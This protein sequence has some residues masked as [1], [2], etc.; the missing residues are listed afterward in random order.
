MADPP[1]GCAPSGSSDPA[2]YYRYFDSED[3]I[4]KPR[5]PAG[6]WKLIE[7]WIFYNYDS[8]HAGALTQW[9]QADWEQVSVLVRR[10]ARTARAVEVAFS[11]HCYG[12]R[13]PAER[14]KW[15][16]SHPLVFVAQGSHA[17]YPRPVSVPARQLRCSLGLTTR[18]LGVAGLFYAPGFDGTALE[19]PVEYVAGIRDHATRGRPI[20]RLRLLD[21]RHSPEV[22]GFHGF[23]G[24]DNKLVVFGIGPRTTGAGPP[25]P[26]TQGPWKQP[27][28]Q[29]LCDK[30]WL[31]MARA[32]RSET[33]W[34]CPPR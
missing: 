9:H 13:L 24:L 23:W 4:H 33:G 8:L 34:V 5:A 11:E 20:A 16:G 12:A 22:T 6:S 19:L 31:H 29:M 27:F 17:N 1:A 2:L 26:S 15:A 7:Y 10:E 32:G 28:A 3:P 18:Y 30:R 21:L 25:A 14:V